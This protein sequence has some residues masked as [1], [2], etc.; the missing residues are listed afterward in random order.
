MPPAF[1]VPVAL[2]LWGYLAADAIARRHNERKHLM[3][4]IVIASSKTE[5]RKRF[6]RAVAVLTP[7]SREGSRGV[8][9]HR[10]VVLRSMDNHPDVLELVELAK[11]SLVT[12]VNGVRVENDD[13]TPPAE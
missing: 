2:L 7:R 6:P 5:G 8:T 1:W 10:I 11:V 4:T 9:A 12:Q 3:D 13:D